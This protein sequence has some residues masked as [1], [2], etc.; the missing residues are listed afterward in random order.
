M[1]LTHGSFRNSVVVPGLSLGWVEPWV[2]LGWVNIFPLLVDWV[3]FSIEK[4]LKL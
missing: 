2:E 4:I 1:A 3:G